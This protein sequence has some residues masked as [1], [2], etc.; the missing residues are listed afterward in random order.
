LHL[1]IGSDL[2]PRGLTL[3]LR[4]HGSTLPRAKSTVV[5]R[6]TVGPCRARW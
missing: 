4:A 2:L 3:S 1:V 5:D 6:R